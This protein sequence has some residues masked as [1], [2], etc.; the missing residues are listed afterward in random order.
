MITLEQ[1]NRLMSEFDNGNLDMWYDDSADYYL[2]FTVYSSKRPVEH[3]ARVQF[4]RS[5]SANMIRRWLVS[6]FKSVEDVDK[7]RDM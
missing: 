3:L 6:T 1:V 2:T 4:M 7:M 5:A